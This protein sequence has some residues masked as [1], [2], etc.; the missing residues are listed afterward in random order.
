V[1]HDECDRCSYGHPP[2]TL[3]STRPAF[4][5]HSRSAERHVSVGTNEFLLTSHSKHEPIYYRFRD[6]A[7]YWSKMRIYLNPRLYNAPLRAL[8]LK[9][10]DYLAEKKLDDI[11]SCLDTIEECDR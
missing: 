8:G 11:F 10:L 6:K 3:G 2:D 9:K 5:G 1:G 4:Q 7:R